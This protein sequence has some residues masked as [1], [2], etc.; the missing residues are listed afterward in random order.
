MNYSFL[1]PQQVLFGWG[2]RTE[3]PQLAARWGRRAFFFSG[4]RTLEHS[5]VIESL[6]DGLRFAAIEVVQ[7]TAPS[8][9]PEVTDVDALTNELLTHQLWQQI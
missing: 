4:S 2:R 6:V 1:T 8:H 9:E 7:F 5:G 3:L